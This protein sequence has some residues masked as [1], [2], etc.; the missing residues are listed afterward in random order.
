MRHSR[1][2]IACAVLSACAASIVAQESPRPAVKSER[3][4][5]PA[6]VPV[7]ETITRKLPD[8]VVMTADVFRRADREKDD[9]VLVCLHQAGGSRGEYR[10]VVNQLLERGFDVF[11]PDL[12]CGGAGDHRDLTTGKR[13]GVPNG[14]WASAK[15]LTG[16]EA[17]FLD[18]YPD[19]DAAVAWARELF[20]T[21]N[22]G[23]VG[24]SYSSTLALVFAAE[25]PG[26][27]DAVFAFSPGDYIEEWSPVKERVRALSIPAYITCG[28]SEAEMKHARP[29]ADAVTKSARLITFWPADEELA[30]GHGSWGL[31][32]ED[33]AAAARQW[34]M[35]TQALETLRPSKK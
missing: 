13:K 27:V 4:E 29:I 6:N 2:L 12:R 9:P 10:L 33:S 35:F 26:R 22:L 20:P 8:T 21:A 31:T 23:L 18:A 5:P 24:S 11:A 25:H 15:E 17:T 30:G 28:S 3:F 34:T 7:P 1:A 32:V 16:R 19:V 14:T